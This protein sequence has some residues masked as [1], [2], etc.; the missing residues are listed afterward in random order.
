MGSNLTSLK[1]MELL[2]LRNQDP[3]M[4]PVQALSNEFGI[5]P[6]DVRVLTKYVNTYSII[7]GKDAKGRETG[8]W[9]E[10]LRGV[11]VQDKP[12]VVKEAEEARATQSSSATSSSSS[13][14]SS[15]PSSKSPITSSS[16]VKD[17]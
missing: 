13:S 12:S 16:K 11:E 7:P 10:D 3:S 14:Q 5:K 17:N 6:E 9:C 1:L 4:W 8:V 15:P 2:Q